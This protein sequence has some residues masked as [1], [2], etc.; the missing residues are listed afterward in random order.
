MREEEEDYNARGQKWSQNKRSLD[1]TKNVSPFLS[2]VLFRILN[3]HLRFLLLSRP[4]SRK[5]QSS[6]KFAQYETLYLF[7]RRLLEFRV[8]CDKKD[9][10]RVLPKEATPRARKT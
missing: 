3:D 5:D 10:K 4:F 2:I 7:F 9:P 1:E 6:F 8:S